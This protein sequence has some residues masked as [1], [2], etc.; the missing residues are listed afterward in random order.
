MAYTTVNK[1]TDYFNTVLWT[2]NGGAN[3]INM[4][5]QPDWTW[6]KNRNLSGGSSQFHHV[7]D[8]V[9]GGNL[10]LVPNEANAES[11]TNDRFNGITSTGFNL[12]GNDNGT[13]GA[14]ATYVA[15]GWKANGQGSSNTDG[16]I[17][18]TYT[19]VNTTAGFSIVSYTGNATTGATVGHGLG[20]A[21]KV[22]IGKNRDANG[23]SWAVYHNSAGNDLTFLDASDAGAA[24]SQIYNNTAPSNS[25]V[26]L[27]NGGNANGNSQNIILYCFAE[28]TGYSKFGKYI[29]NA[30]ANGTF[31]YTG[32]KPAWV[33]LKQINTT[34]NW[35]LFDNKRPGYNLTA[36]FLEPDAY[37]AEAVNNPNNRIDMLSNGF[38]IRGSGTATNASGGTYIYMAFGQSIVGTN[39]IPATAR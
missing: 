39:N 23:N 20:V 6:I 15:W 18:T 34:N 32:F 7:Y 28:K 11:A 22:V 24:Y 31:V 19:S 26:T 16:S 33:L 10:R 3:S 30:N 4:G 1:S 13:N 29:G 17:N 12:V 36:N 5:L 21:P 9:R 2:G 8:S 25:V 38:K 37:G 27:G 14:G 35:L